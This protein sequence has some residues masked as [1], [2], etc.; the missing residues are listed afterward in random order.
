MTIMYVQLFFKGILRGRILR[1]KI[2]TIHFHEINNWQRCRNVA[3]W[4]EKF[5]EI[6]IRVKFRGDFQDIK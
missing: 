3:E 1:L 6:V 4:I 5:F 2:K